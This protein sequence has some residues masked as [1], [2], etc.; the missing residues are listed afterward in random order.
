LVQSTLTA[1][2]RKFHEQ[3][4]AANKKALAAGKRQGLD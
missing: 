2:T 4:E 1:A 3:I